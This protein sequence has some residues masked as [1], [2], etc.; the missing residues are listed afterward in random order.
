MANPARTSTRAIEKAR[1]KNDIE[2]DSSQTFI[3]YFPV[4]NTY[5]LFPANDENWPVHFLNAE[6][7]S[8]KK[9]DHVI[10]PKIGKG[11]FMTSGPLD[12]MVHVGEYM[13]SNLGDT[14]CDVARLDVSAVIK[15]VLGAVS[16][17]SNERESQSDSDDSDLFSEDEEQARSH[18]QPA[19]CK[20]RKIEKSREVPVEKGSKCAACGQVSG[21][22]SALKQLAYEKLLHIA[23]RLEQR[24]DKSNQIQ[25]D[26]LLLARKVMKEVTDAKEA[27]IERED[28]TNE[29]VGEHV[30][31]QGLCLTNL[32]GDTP[33]EKGKRIARK[34]WSKEELANHVVDPQKKLRPENSGRTRIDLEREAVFRNALKAVLGEQFSKKVYKR[35]VRLINVM[36][37]AYKNKGYKENESD[38]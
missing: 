31:Y 10:F 18:S 4:D 14:T 9:L 35:V 25:K 11:L 22:K 27:V 7:I 26:N 28:G 21:E 34:L 17:T 23:S 15:E 12:L 6:K 37:N 1:L 30:Y 24:L 19:P 5:M 3:F 36:G 13:N 32:G 33:E 20:R 38:Y 16:K 2:L 8:L 29:E